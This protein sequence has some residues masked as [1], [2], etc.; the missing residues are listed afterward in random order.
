M[1]VLGTRLGW[2]A[3]LAVSAGL[4]LACRGDN[5]LSG[6]VDQLFPL[7]V[8]RVDMLRNEQAFQVSYYANRGADIDLV[9]RVTLFVG[10]AGFEPGQTLDL[11]G[12]YTEGHPR[13]TVIHLASGEPTRV[14]PRVERGD[15]IL[16]QG[17]GIDQ[18]TRGNF[19][20]LF[21]RGDAFGAGRTLEG[22]FA[23]LPRDAGYD[24]Y[25]P[26]T[27]SPGSP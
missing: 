2:L 22:T 13:T 8:S 9:A 11:A 19:S 15:L 1:N 7:S 4:I 25:L 21:E 17:G 10:D 3:S 26:E 14:F 18:P 23:G 6:S 5:E 20:M 16:E 12:E 27:A 24:W